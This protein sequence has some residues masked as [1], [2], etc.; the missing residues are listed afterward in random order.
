LSAISFRADDFREGLEANDEDVAALYEQ[1]ATAY[2]VPEKR[3]LRFVL[4]DVPALKASFT[5]SD[6]DIQSYYDNNLDRYTEP[7]TLRASHILLRNSDDDAAAVQARAEAIV[8]EA[9]AGADFAALAQEHS[10]DV[11]TKDLGGD[12]GEIAPVPP[13]VTATPR[14]SSPSP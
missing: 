8:A 6:L 5:P 10:E 9:R 2:L 1:N 4:I 11:A 13:P 12:L 7:T 3:R 14:R